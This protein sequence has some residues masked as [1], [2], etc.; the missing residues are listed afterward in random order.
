MKASPRPGTLLNK[1]RQSAPERATCESVDVD[2][3]EHQSLGHSLWVGA[4]YLHNQT[5]ALGSQTVVV[6]S[7]ILVQASCDSHANVE[8]QALDLNLT[9]GIAL[10]NQEKSCRCSNVHFM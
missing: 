3:T 8:F 2:H 10:R 9:P 6:L 5:F 7:Q 1:Y 4:L